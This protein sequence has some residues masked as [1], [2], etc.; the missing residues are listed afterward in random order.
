MAY[1]ATRLTRPI[2]VAIMLFLIVLFFVISP[3]I[4]MYTAGYRYDLAT[5]TIKET[6]VISIDIVPDDATVLLN[7]VAITKRMPIRLAN[8]APGRYSL[9]IEKTGYH[10]L[11]RD[12]DVVSKQTTYIRD[13]TLF[14]NTLPA[15]VL[16]PSITDSTQLTMSYDGR[17]ALITSSTPTGIQDISLADLNNAT[18]RSI[19]R[20]PSSTIV[21][22]EW[23]PRQQIAYIQTDH[24]GKKTV[25]FVHAANPERQFTFT[26]PATSTIMHQWSEARNNAGVYIAQGNRVSYLTSD[27]ISEFAETPNHVWYIDGDSRRFEYDQ[28]QSILYRYESRERVSEWRLSKPISQI[29]QVQK[30]FLI[31]KY[32]SGMAI[33]HFSDTT[34]DVQEIP[35]EHIRFNPERNE[36]LAWSQSELWRID[37]NGHAALLT[38]LSSEITDVHALDNTGSILITTGSQLIGFYPDFFNLIPLFNRSTTRTAGVNQKSRSI[39]FTGQVGHTESLF[40]LKY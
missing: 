20:V 7:G 8:R 3:V 31:A 38:R 1:P 19:V 12:I 37:N 4:L 33:I 15:A 39:Y 29:I 16:S 30:N 22:L 2:R 28:A 25:H 10:S 32:A 34:L 27:G 13:L 9:T 35:T 21:T 5:H 40:E 26:F 11:H 23:S 17:Y 14:R 18:E 24:A 6:G 36:W